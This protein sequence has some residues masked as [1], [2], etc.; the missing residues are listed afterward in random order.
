MLGP[1]IYSASSRAR[2]VASIASRFEWSIAK[3]SASCG[4]IAVR[5][6]SNDNKTESNSWKFAPICCASKPLGDDIVEVCIIE[7][8]IVGEDTIDVF[9]CGLGWLPWSPAGLITPKRPPVES[10]GWLGPAS[11]K[12]WGP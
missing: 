8:G 11:K 9:A 2:T 12:R 6:E 7:E 1:A 3:K 5:L 10:P 4:F